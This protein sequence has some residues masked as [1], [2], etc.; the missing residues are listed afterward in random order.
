MYDTREEARQKLEGT[1]VI[2]EGKPVIVIEA[3]NDSNGGVRLAFSRLPS[4]REIEWANIED[5]KWDFRNMGAHLGYMDYF[6]DKVGEPVYSVRV[7]RRQS[8][9][10]LCDS[11]VR[12]SIFLN[13]K[14]AGYAP[15]FA[16]MYVQE[17]FVR[18]M[19]LGKR[20]PEKVFRDLI[21]A[22]SNTYGQSINKKLALYW[23]RVNPPNLLY[24]GKRIGYT[25]DGSNYKLAPMFTHL[26]EELVDM[27]NLK[28]A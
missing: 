28:I 11:N 21:K 7:P 6:M 24:R 23:D 3:A 19:S 12:T 25:E 20:D 5:K 22:P 26:T 14:M 13:D 10:G 8:K 15:E 9:Q 16:R 1:I 18:M 4:K 2:Y 27:E 17:D